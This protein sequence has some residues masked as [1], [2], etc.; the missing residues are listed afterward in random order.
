MW[1][2]LTF[3]YQEFNLMNLIEPSNLLNFFF[4]INWKICSF[5]L[6]SKKDWEFFLWR[7][8]QNWENEL[9][10]L[11]YFPLRNFYQIFLIQISKFADLR[12]KK[13]K[14]IKIKILW[15]NGRFNT[16]Q[17][18]IKIKLNHKYFISNVMINLNFISNFC[19]SISLSF[20]KS[21][22]KLSVEAF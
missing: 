15:G 8:P 2:E 13:D 9:T 5:F 14:E 12:E 21:N 19:E 11:E 4:E 6:S 22:L 20:L 10:F 7:I 16:V 18:K 3:I 17:L 1:N